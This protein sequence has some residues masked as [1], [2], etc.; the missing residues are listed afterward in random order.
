MPYNLHSLAGSS[1]PLCVICK[2]CGHRSTVPGE[3]LGA[4]SGNMQEIW[5]LRLVCSKCQSHSFD[6]YVMA[7]E[8]HTADFI[9]GADLEQYAGLKA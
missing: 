7:T 3:R 6:A 4:H 8:K 9:A 5:R 1:Q 2:M